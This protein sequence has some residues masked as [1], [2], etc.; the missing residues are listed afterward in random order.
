MSRFR[1]FLLL[2][3]VLALFCEGCGP[4]IIKV[5]ITKPAEINLKGIKKI[6]VGDISGFMGR[7]FADELT[8]ALFNSGRYEVLDRQNLYSILKEQNLSWDGITDPEQSAQLGAVIGAAA[9]VVGRV[10]EYPYN[11]EMT[12]SDGKNKDGSTYRIYTRKGKAKL[13]INLKVVEVQTGKILAT[14]QFSSSY[15][16]EKWEKNQH[17]ASIDTVGL[18][19]ACRGKIVEDFMK[20]IAPYEVYSHMKFYSDSKIPELE[21]GISMAKIGNWE[22]AKAHFQSAVDKNPDSWKAHFDL[23]TAYKCTGDYE[24]AIGIFTKA[25]AIESKPEISSEIDYCK[26]RIEEEKKLKEQ[27]EE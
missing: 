2:L 23:A 8:T 27:M 15:E 17:P 22:G 18:Y 9:L 24:Q 20:T 3:V 14:K 6:A 21:K 1:P 12:Y 7:D 16:Q 5:P 26:K 19:K 13:V 4:T 25:Y 10:S 11:E